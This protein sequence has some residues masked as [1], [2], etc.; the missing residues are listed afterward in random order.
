MILKNTLIGLLLLWSCSIATAQ[1]SSGGLP[2]SFE[3]PGLKTKIQKVT[4][5]AIPL[6]DLIRED[7]LLDASDNPY[8]FGYLFEVDYSLENAGQWETLSDGSKLW[9]LQIECPGALSINLNYSDFELPRGA[10]LFIYN[11]DRSDV[12][13]AFTHENNKPYRKFSTIPVRGDRII[14]EYHEPRKTYKPGTIRIDGIVHGYRNIH[15]ALA[16]SGSCN[17]DVVC[18]AGDGFPEVDNWRDQIR[19]VVALFTPGNIGFCTGALINNTN[20]DCTPY[21]LT[22]RHCGFGT[23]NVSDNNL[24]IFNYENSF[25]RQPNST[26]SGQAGNGS[27]AQSISGMTVIATSGGGGGIQISDFALIELSAQP[28]TSYNAHYAG[29]SRSNLAPS[30]AV[31]IH[32]PSVD[33]KRIV[34]KTDSLFI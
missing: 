7:E 13:G 25:C 33:E 3:T 12:I 20:L 5:P 24:F 2:V 15:E 28:P 8:R 27:L 14:L 1:I 31:A 29:W 10:K 16:K 26:A 34:F 22:A 23:P 32:H 19:S 21:I 6:D 11:E 30:G 9:R 17:L 18:G 4:M